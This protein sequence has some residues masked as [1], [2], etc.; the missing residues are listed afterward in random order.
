MTSGVVIT[1]SLSP[2]RA[3]HRYHI[4]QAGTNRLGE[5]NPAGP[6]SRRSPY[7]SKGV[8]AFIS[9]LSPAIS[10]ALVGQCRLTVSKPVFQA[11]MVS[12]LEATI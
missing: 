8:R 5:H 2:R 1:R 12:A 4:N 9:D 6:T 3:T 7:L 10:L 11:P